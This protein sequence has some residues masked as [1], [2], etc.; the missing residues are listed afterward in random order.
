[1]QLIACSYRELL[2]GWKQA[3]PASLSTYGGDPGEVRNMTGFAELEQ[4]C[5]SREVE[6][7]ISVMSASAAVNAG[8]GGICVAYA[9]RHG[10]YGARALRRIGTPCMG[11]RVI[12][13]YGVGGSVPRY[14]KRKRCTSAASSN[15]ASISAK[16][17]PMQVRGP[18]PKGM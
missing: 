18:P 6:L 13:G 17:S 16:R 8:A 3:E 1:V 5:R 2:T 15:T 14:S 7:L 11:R 12:E 10:A 4:V 9:G